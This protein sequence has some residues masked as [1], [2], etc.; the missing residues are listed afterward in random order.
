MCPNIFTFIFSCGKKYG[1]QDLCGPR[2]S[3]LAR[4]RAC[5]HGVSWPDLISNLNNWTTWLGDLLLAGLLR[6]WRSECTQK[7]PHSLLPCESIAVKA[8]HCGS[9]SS[10]WETRQHS[11]TH[12]KL[13]TGRFKSPNIMTAPYVEFKLF[14]VPKPFQAFY[15]S[16]SVCTGF[17]YTNRLMLTIIWNRTAIFKSVRVS[18]CFFFFLAAVASQKA[19]IEQRE[20]CEDV[21]HQ[22]IVNLSSYRGWTCNCPHLPSQAIRCQSMEPCPDDDVMKSVHAH[23]EVTSCAWMRPTQA[24]PDQNGEGC[25][26]KWEVT[27]PCPISCRLI[28]SEKHFENCMTT[29]IKP[30]GEICQ[31]LFYNPFWFLD[32][33]AAGRN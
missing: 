32:H 4:T 13:S 9:V 26:D 31:Y 23:A 33:R 5:T 11:H 22:T 14:A 8:W 15:F 2:A 25:A 16:T 12:L 6:P 3:S 30:W 24:E 1:K 18:N 21:C 19:T 20:T 10:V 28:K 17:A 7:N 27:S 29:P